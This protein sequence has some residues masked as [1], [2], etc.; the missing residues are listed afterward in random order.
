MLLVFTASVIQ[1]TP[2]LFVLFSVKPV[3]I[4][5][6]CVAVSAMEGEYEGAF[7]GAFGGLLW[8]LSVGNVA[9]LFAILLSLTC[10]CTGYL[11]KMYF[12]QNRLNIMLIN[13]GAVTFIFMADFLF[14][15]LLRNY[16]G[17]SNILLFRMLPTI[18][19]T[20]LI[21]PIPFWAARKIH[22]KIKERD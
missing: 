4:L 13:G 12:R 5:P 10:F 3:W 17:V 8:D 1:G 9:G 18:I 22:E 6:V 15:Y 7:L 20:A 19:Y 11:F 21:S 16:T 14:N 2:G